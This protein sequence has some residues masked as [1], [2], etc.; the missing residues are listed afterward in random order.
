MAMQEVGSNRAEAVKILLDEW[1]LTDPRY[2]KGQT[3]KVMR[4]TENKGEHRTDGMTLFLNIDRRAEPGEGDIEGKIKVRSYLLLAKLGL[5]S[6]SDLSIRRRNPEEGDFKEGHDQFEVSVPLDKTNRKKA[7]EILLENEQAREIENA[8]SV[9]PGIGRTARIEFEPVSGDHVFWYEFLLKEAKKAGLHLY[10]PASLPVENEKASFDIEV[11]K[12]G[13]DT[14]GKIKQAI[15]AANEQF[16]LFETAPIW[17]A[18][19]PDPAPDSVEK[20]AAAPDPLEKQIAMEANVK[21]LFER[22]GHYPRTVRMH[23]DH[24]V[25]KFEEPVSEKELPR[26][27]TAIH[28]AMN[29]VQPAGKRGK[30][31]LAYNQTLLPVKGAPTKETPHTGIMRLLTRKKSAA[32]NT[33]SEVTLRI[34]KAPAQFGPENVSFQ[35]S[36]LHEE[37]SNL[38][39]KLAMLDWK[40]FKNAGQAKEG[41]IAMGSGNDPLARRLREERRLIDGL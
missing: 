28:E 41:G 6:I 13:L 30:D 2:G 22:M 3:A 25:V 18:P 33:V 38:T 11:G 24:F 37:L 14:A 40:H 12:M 21:Q 27:A 35:E 29:R 26:I 39:G 8:C 1:S 17:P 34:W 5:E 15:L 9:K 31:N 36:I 7:M 19:A 32:E 10:L 20:Q 23:D 4:D 16:K